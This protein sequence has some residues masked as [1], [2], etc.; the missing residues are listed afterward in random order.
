MDE[1]AH[2]GAVGPS[3]EDGAATPFSA[4]IAAPDQ[5]PAEAPQPAS[6][7]EFSGMLPRVAGG[8][9]GAVAALVIAPVAGP[10]QPEASAIEPPAAAPEREQVPAAS[11]TD[12][13]PAIEMPAAAEPEP[14]P[15][16]EQ[17]P[18]ASPPDMAPA[19]EAPL[20]QPVSPPS[21]I[22]PPVIPTIALV[23][24]RTPP[25]PPALPPRPLAYA[26][27]EPWRHPLPPPS[28]PPPS[29]VGGARYL[30]L[31]VRYGLWLLL[32]VLGVVLALILAYRWIDPPASTLMLMQR[33]DGTPITQRWVPLA[34]IS[35]NLQLAA[36]LSEDARFCRHWGVD[37]G[38]LEE[39]IDRARDGIPRGGSTISMQVVKN[40]FLWPSKSYLRK[41]IEI[42]LTYVVEAAWSK[43]R[44][45]E[46]YLNIA[47]WGPGI[48]GADA[49]ARYHFRK[50]ASLLTPREAA[51][52]AVA[53][54][55]PFE[56]Q[57][58]SPGPG[59][60]RLA[61]NLLA[62]MRVAPG[63]AGCVRARP[64]G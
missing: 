46:V 6:A 34:R 16:P 18:V 25:E 61:D 39:A 53:L 36:V 45:L 19:I 21:G 28:V 30:R 38:E 43:A 17:V 10:A 63:N 3:A 32:A 41:A 9:A 4:G 23:R 15:E 52:L 50:P 60:Q 59:T 12:T 54:P 51:L 55:N 31:A 11:P 22:A 62:R 47:E 44:I 2:E 56:R 57:A 1:R 29:R 64:S 48:F 33:L 42:P 13:A 14:E 49:A 20:P 26:P 7:P 40:L 24:A 37:W 8:G 58:G 27:A 35:P 5:A